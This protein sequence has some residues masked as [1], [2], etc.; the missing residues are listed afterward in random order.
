MTHPHDEEP[1]M[2]DLDV[3]AFDEYEDEDIDV[4]EEQVSLAAG[5]HTLKPEPEEKGVRLDKFVADHAPGLSRSFVQQLIEQGKVLVDG[6]APKAKFKVTP[7]QLIQLEVPEPEIVELQPEAI[8]LDIVFENADVIVL[9]KPAGMVVH[10]APGHP[11]GTLVNALLHHAPDI[12]VGGTN[13]PGIIH[14]LDRDTSGL[15][16]VVKTDKART[17]LVEQWQA[18]TVE[19]GYIALGHGEIDVEEATINAPIGR[20]PK[21]RKKMAAVRGGR[22]AITHLKVA[23]RLTGATLFDVDLETGRTH[24]I[25]VHLAF[26]GHP[27]VGD[28]IYNKY[29]GRFGG[30]GEAVSPRQFLH[31][32]KLAFRLP[33]GKGVSFEAPLPADLQAVLETARER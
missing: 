5:M 11:S 25:R 17:T 12:N 20:D 30:R 26:I 3:D 4:V 22:P 10:P 29:G 32:A 2:I 18:R 23:E 16:V 21:D 33:G 28:T 6:R 31:A 19:K 7:G 9:N 24:Q 15:M 1:W 27:I 14:R 13:R 8:D